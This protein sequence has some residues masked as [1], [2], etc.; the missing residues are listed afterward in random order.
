MSEFLNT[1]IEEKSSD[2]KD[3]SGKLLRDNV[4][5]RPNRDAIPQRVR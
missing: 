2:F 3:G 5:F 1:L 4:E